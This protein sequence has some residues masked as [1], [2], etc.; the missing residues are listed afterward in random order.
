MEFYMEG[1]FIYFE[2]DK[3]VTNMYC[4]HYFA[5]NLIYLGFLWI[6]IER[7]PFKVAI[8]VFK[9]RKTQ[10]KDFVLQLGVITRRVY[11]FLKCMVILIVSTVS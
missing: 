8:F 1:L 9:A 11:A 10:L 7:D 4:S 3:K 5:D 6:F 2:Y